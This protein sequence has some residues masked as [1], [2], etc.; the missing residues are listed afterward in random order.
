[1]STSAARQRARNAGDQPCDPVRAARRACALAPPPSPRRAAGRRVARAL[2]ALLN[3]RSMERVALRQP[4][5]DAG[6]GRFRRSFSRL[7]R[8]SGARVVR[9]A[10]RE[11]RRRAMS[12]DRSVPA[13][14]PSLR[15]WVRVLDALTVAFLFVGAFAM[16]HP[17]RFEA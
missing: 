8:P 9:R 5:P 6:D 2:P 17:L 4:V 7:R 15:W 3:L 10:R 12:D 11:A 1:R 13:E 14:R 16:F